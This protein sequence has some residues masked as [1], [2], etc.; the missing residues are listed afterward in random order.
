MEEKQRNLSVELRP[1]K[2]SEF[3]GQEDLISELKNGMEKR[4]PIGIILSGESGTGKTTIAEILALAIQCDHGQFGEPCDYCI[5]NSNL[6]NIST[7]PCGEIGNIAEMRLLLSGLSNYPSYGKYRVIIL[8]E[9]QEI[10]DK[11]Q[12]LLLDPLEDKISRN[13]FILTTNNASK[14]RDTI[15]RRCKTFMTSGLSIDDTYKLVEITINK[16]EGQLTRPVEPLVE[17]L[18]KAQ[19]T[20]PGF[21]VKA[22][23]KYLDGA[24]IATCIAVKDASKIDRIA[25]IQAVTQGNWSKCQILLKEATAA[26]VDGLKT[27]LAGYFRSILVNPKNSD[28]R[29][30]FAANSI[31]ELSGN[32]ASVVWESGFQLSVLVASIYKICNKVKELSKQ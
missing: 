26:D 14:I 1:T 18:V 3:I 11:A 29:L 21:I 20:S 7:H 25:L 30:E 24:T 12:G 2:L 8:D 31:H 27:H 28:K 15:K 9:A 10:G 19:V 5:D 16:A 32:N 17:G 13:I 4:V 6:F 23:E 22:V